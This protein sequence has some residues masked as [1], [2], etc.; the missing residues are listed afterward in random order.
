[1]PAGDPDPDLP[2]L[3]AANAPS[4][5]NTPLDPDPDTAYL[6]ALGAQGGGGIDWAKAAKL[7][8]SSIGGGGR[9][10]GAPTGSGRMLP[11]QMP[12]T[13]LNRPLP[14]APAA[15]ADSQNQ[16]ALIAY[17]SDAIRRAQA[18]NALTNQPQT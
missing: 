1:M 8:G 16:Q 9:G 13:S 18:A 7:L 12:L 10:A 17:L 3:Q 2:Y 15:S 4:L 14:Q 11:A 6:Q 5:L